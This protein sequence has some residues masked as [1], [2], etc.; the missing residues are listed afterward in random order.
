LF[1]FRIIVSSNPPPFLS[2]FFQPLNYDPMSSDTV[3]MCYPVIPVGFS[4]YVYIH[5]LQ[6]KLVVLDTAPHIL[7]WPP[8]L[9]HSLLPPSLLLPLSSPPSLHCSNVVMATG[10]LHH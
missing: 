8:S 10:S 5:A 2:S 9:L 6:L 3:H 4:R 7:P 1:H